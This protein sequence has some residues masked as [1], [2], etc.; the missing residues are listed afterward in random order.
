[1]FW[2]DNYVKEGHSL[3]VADNHLS[4]DQLQKLAKRVTKF[5]KHLLKIAK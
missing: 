5:R 2:P 1:M 3:K 4:R